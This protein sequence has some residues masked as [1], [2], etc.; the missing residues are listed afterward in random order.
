MATDERRQ[1]LLDDYR[2]RLLESRELEDKVKQGLGEL[3]LRT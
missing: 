1:K 3:T 2:K